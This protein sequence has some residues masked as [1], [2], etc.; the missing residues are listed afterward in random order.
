VLAV[1]FFFAGLILALV[2]TGKAEAVNRLYACDLAG[3]G[4]GCGAVFLIYS[5]AGEARTVVLVCLI[6]GLGSLA[7]S[8]NGWRLNLVR[9]PWM[10]LLFV[11]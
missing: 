1:P 6:S 2:Y 5:F 7:F 9:G 10:V 8:T 3:A 4:L 11:P